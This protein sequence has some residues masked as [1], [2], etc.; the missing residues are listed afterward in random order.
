MGSSKA[1]KGG[2]LIGDRID[3]DTTGGAG[4]WAREEVDRTEK[5][6][7]R[8]PHRKNSYPGPLWVNIKSIMQNPWR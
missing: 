1:G 4:T 5:N 3:G 7:D 8:T 2:D 6:R